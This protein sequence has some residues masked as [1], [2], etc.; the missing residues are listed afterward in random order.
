MK[1]NK[2]VK[3]GIMTFELVPTQIIDSCIGC[4]YEGYL[5]STCS[6]SGRMKRCEH[7]EHSYIFKEIIK[8]DEPHQEDEDLERLFNGTT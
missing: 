2:I 7:N 6:L 4:Y 8:K 5:I 3:D 1:K